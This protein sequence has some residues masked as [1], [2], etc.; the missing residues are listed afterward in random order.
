[1]QILRSSVEG[2]EWPALPGPDAGPLLALLFQLEQSQWWSPEDLQIMQYRQL[3][4]LLSHAY[5]TVPFYREQ[6]VSVGYNPGKEITQEEFSSLP[7]LHRSQVQSLW[8]ALH[9][10]QV[11]KSHGA[12]YE[13]QTSGSTGKPV[14]ALGTDLTRLFWSVMTLRDHLWHKR[15]FSGKLAA[16]RTKVPDV[17][18]QGWGLPADSVFKTGVLA[19]LNIK[20]DLQ[21]QMTWL[22]E[23]KP[24]YL[25]SLAS[26]IKGLAELSL[27]T[28]IK[29][30]ELREIR[31]FGEVVS[32][33]L[34]RLCCDAWGVK[35]ADMYSA[36]EIGYMALQCPEHE[37]YHVQSE[38][39]LLEVLDENNRACGPGEIGRVVIT[40]LHNFAMPLIRY[41]ILDYAEMGELCSCGRGLPVIRRVMGRQRHL[42]TFP[43]GRRHW[44]S[45]P[46]ETW[47][48]VAPIRQ[49]QLIQKALDHIHVKLV[50]DRQLTNDEEKQI[51]PL[52]QKGLGYPFR[53]TFECLDRIERNQNFK[54]EDFISEI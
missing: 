52:L 4:C 40:P 45:Y 14:K 3:S 37:H 49:Y 27:E 39:V 22:Q 42:I 32:P 2:I 31:T 34:R 25:L 15:D 46:P 20:A 53:M 28:G 9:S 44:P 12:V 10:R 43:D 26:N 8:E 1:V 33:E 47:A 48:Y 19:T 38:S 54:Y 17:V 11:P 13:L 24:D 5:E 21:T 35:V 18:R 6:L 51:V 41:E 50:M 29:L 7:I 16:I 36:E 23:H 30:P